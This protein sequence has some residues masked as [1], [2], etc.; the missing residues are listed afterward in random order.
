[1]KQHIQGGNIKEFEFKQGQGWRAGP[2]EVIDGESF[3]VGLIRY[4][5][6][7]IFGTKSIEAKALIK[8]GEV[9]M[10]IWP[11]SGMEIK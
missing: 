8:N 11:K 9:V 1:M 2:D 6:E 5:A 10:W 3:Q 7:T 4:M